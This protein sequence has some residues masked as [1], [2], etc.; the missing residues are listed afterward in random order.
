VVRDTVDATSGEKR[1]LVAIGYGLRCVPVTQLAD[2]AQG[3]GDLDWMDGSRNDNVAV[4][5]SVHD[6]AEVQLVNRRLHEEVT[7]THANVSHD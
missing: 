5:G 4:V 6:Y 1:P 7:V 3:V 2:A